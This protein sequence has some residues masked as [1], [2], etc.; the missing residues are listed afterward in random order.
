MIGWALVAVAV[1]L[2]ANVFF[3]AV[4]FALVA[5]RRTR[6]EP[7]ASE[8][9]R[10]AKLALAAMKDLNPQLAGAQL[11]ITM[12]S[13][14]LGFVAEPAVGSV[15]E[16]LAGTVTDPES[17]VVRTLSIAV[18]LVIVVFFHMV[19]GEMVPK[20][21]AIADPERTLLRL[22]GGNRVYMVAL[23]PVIR[24]LNAMASGAIRLLGV[25]PRDELRAGHTADELATML[26]Q[27]ADE[28]MIEDFA[29][30]LL[31]GA[32]DFGERRVDSV[33]VPKSAVVIVASEATV[34]EVE[35]IVV[36]RGH[37]RLPVVERDGGEPLGFVHAKDLLS[38]SPAAHGR[39]LPRHLV[40]RM[41]RVPP[42]RNLADLLLSMRVAR[43]HVAVVTDET[44]R[45]VGLVTLEDLLEALVGEIMD[46][47][48][49]AR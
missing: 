23:G 1:L 48:D 44:G 14:A 28:G 8:G 30:A 37:S 40:R 17:A 9:S 21:V 12:A 11:G 38:L 47:S 22:A 42:E 39:P 19:L 15:I 27:S 24:L 45:M 4:E 13:L 43:V 10:A 6:I 25:E 34:S 35:E 41:L 33:M 46:E 31:S 36:A 26:R 49:R 20:N 3:T 5:S 32:L 7:L 29:H 16:R 2:A 18:S